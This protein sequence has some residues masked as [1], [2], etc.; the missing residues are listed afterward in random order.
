LQF[1]RSS[2]QPEVNARTQRAVATAEL[3]PRVSAFGDGALLLVLG[4][5]IDPALSRRIHAIAEHLRAETANDSRWG[6]PVPG[7]GSLLL[8]YDPLALSHEEATGRLDRFLWSHTRQPRRTR[9]PRPVDAVEIP[10]RYGGEDGPDLEE[11]A[12]ALG[13]TPHQVVDLHA[14]AEYDVLL[15]GFAP[16]FAY[17]GPLPPKLSLPRRATPRTRVPPGSVA[18]AGRQTA[19]YPSSTPGGW[20]LIGRTDLVMWD[21]AREPPALLRPGQRVRFRPIRS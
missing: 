17:L 7:Y 13:L 9:R 4:D 18:I 10:V 16:G 2:G 14:E 21:A 3:R 5:A 6:S 8:P 1:D 12:R 20:H 11:A 15:L 19:V